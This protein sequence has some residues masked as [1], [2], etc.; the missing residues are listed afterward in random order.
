MVVFISLWGSPRKGQDSSFSHVQITFRPIKLVPYS[1]DVKI[2][3]DDGSFSVAICASIPQALV[4]IPVQLDF[5][6]CAVNEV[7]QHLRES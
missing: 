1:D 4:K 6:F 2:I 3:T 5:G 7:R